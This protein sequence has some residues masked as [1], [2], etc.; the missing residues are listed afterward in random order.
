[1]V[2][3]FCISSLCALAQSG[4]DFSRLK[5]EEYIHVNYSNPKY[6]SAFIVL[7]GIDGV[8]TPY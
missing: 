3:L 5:E 6:W 8:L 2:L 7:D 1:M 4:L